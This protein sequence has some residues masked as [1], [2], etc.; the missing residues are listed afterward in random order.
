MY[1]DFFSDFLVMGGYVVYVWSVFGLIY[2]FMVMLWI[3]SV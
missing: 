3:V 1:F 2:F